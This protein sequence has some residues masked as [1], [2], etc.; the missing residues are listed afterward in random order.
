MLRVP[1]QVQH[2]QTNLG[3]LDYLNPEERRLLLWSMVALN[4]LNLLYACVATSFTDPRDTTCWPSQSEPD[5]VLPDAPCREA[6]RG[7]GCV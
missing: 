4:E 3:S 6:E 7:L 1:M 5:A 2:F